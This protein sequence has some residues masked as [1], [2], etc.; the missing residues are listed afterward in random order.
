M[1][2]RHRYLAFT[3]L[4]EKEKIPREVAIRTIWQSVFRFF[5]ELKASEFDLWIMAYDEIERKGIVR[6]SL[7]MVDLLRASLAT[8]TEIDGKRAAFHVLGTSGTVKA[9][10]KKFLTKHEKVH[11]ITEI[12]QKIE[13]INVSGDVVRIN[14]CGEIDILPDAK[15]RKISERTK[16]NFIGLTIFDLEILK[17]GSV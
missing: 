11:K 5:G 10:T 8:V 16:S 15:S 4:S 2:A 3:I 17:K 13:L 12:E 1:H 7:G 9:A 6:C 14:P